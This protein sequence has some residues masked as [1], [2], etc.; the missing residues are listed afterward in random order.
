VLALVERLVERVRISPSRFARAAVRVRSGRAARKVTQQF[1][2]VLYRLQ[3][4]VSS[5]VSEVYTRPGHH[6]CLPAA[7]QQQLSEIVQP[8]DVLMTR[9]EFALTNYFLPGYWPHAALYLGA[10][11]ELRALGVHQHEHFASRW[12]RLLHVDPLQPRRV[13]EAMKDG[14]W[15]RSLASPLSSDAVGVLRPKLSRE[16]IAIGLTRGMFHE[17]KAYD[18]DFDFTRSDRLVCTEVVYRSY[19]GL[20][21][22][23][24]PLTRRAGRLTLAAEDIIRLALDGQ[25]LEPVAAY[26]PAFAPCVVVGD[27]AA[28]ALRATSQGG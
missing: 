14:V 4:M 2:R 12:E 18:F 13:L 17:G 24:F 25:G 9:K 1:G 5:M 23:R 21:G 8:G 19:D 27:Q 20:G 6:P 3:Q 11:E 15:I 26:A 16:Q 22:L 10:A 7:V 28:D